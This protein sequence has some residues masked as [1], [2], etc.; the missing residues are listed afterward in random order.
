ML[1]TLELQMP[2]FI[3]MAE[4]VRLDITRVPNTKYAFEDVKTQGAWM[5]FSQAY[6]LGVRDGMKDSWERMK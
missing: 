6:S 3:R 1:D 5:I 4:E 2:V